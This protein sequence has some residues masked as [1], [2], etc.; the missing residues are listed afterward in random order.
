MSLGIKIQESWPDN[1]K[2]AKILCPITSQATKVTNKYISIMEK[3][4]KSLDEGTPLDHLGHRN[5]PI[6]EGDYD[7][8]DSDNSISLDS[9]NSSFLD[10][11]RE[12]L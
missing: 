7:P 6:I 8:T 10:S 5:P 2:L 12:E 1:V 11:S 4:R 9:V 3:S